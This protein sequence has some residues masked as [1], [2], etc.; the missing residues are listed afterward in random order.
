MSRNFYT[1]SAF[2]TSMSSG[3]GKTCIKNMLP[4]YFLTRATRT[5]LCTVLL[6][7]TAVVQLPD[8]TIAGCPGCFSEEQGPDSPD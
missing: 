5:L 7:I 2:Q 3:F 8:G 6:G 1:L 4:S